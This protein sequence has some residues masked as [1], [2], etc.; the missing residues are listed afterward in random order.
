MNDI[1]RAVPVPDDA[2]GS[3]RLVSRSGALVAVMTHTEAR[4][5]GEAIFKAGCD[6]L[7]TARRIEDAALAAATSAPTDDDEGLGPVPAE[8]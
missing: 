4:E 2:D 8:V 7:A 6:G 1:L 5:L 3:V